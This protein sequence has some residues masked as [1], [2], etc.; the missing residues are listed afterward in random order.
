M[1]ASPRRSTRAA[2]PKKARTEEEK[3]AVV[4]EKAVAAVEAA[5]AVA[6]SSPAGKKKGAKKAAATEEKPAAVEVAAPVAEAAD[7][8][9]EQTP[10]VSAAVAADVPEDLLVIS[11]AEEEDDI[12]VDDEDKTF[13]FPGAEA[14]M[15]EMEKEAEIT[16]SI[17]QLGTMQHIASDDESDSSDDE[18]TL[19]RVGDIP[20]EWYKD[21]GHVGY[22]VEGRKLMKKERSAL[23]QLLD[24]TDDPN[25][26]RTIYDAL[27]DE[28]KVLSNAEL[29][30]IFNLQRN[31]TPNSAYDM[32]AD[33]PEGMVKFD[34]LN[35]PLARP[36]G[37][38]KKKFVPALHDM[39]VVAKMVK[40]LM[41]GKTISDPEKENPEDKPEH[42]YLL[43]DDA[44]HVQMDNKTKFKY[45]NR[46]EKPSAAPPGTYESYRPPAE[47]LPSEK[48]IAKFK[49]LRNIDKKE[50]FLPE[51][52]DSLRHVPFYKRTI[53][54]R[55][56]RCLDLSLYPRRQRTRLIVDPS[57]LLPELP[58]PKDLRPFPERLS[59]LYK[60]HTACVRSI[61]VNPTGEYLA[62][63]CDD[64]LVRV[65][66]VLTGRLMKRY[67]LG[68]PVQ[69]V[70]FSPS[71]SHN[72]LAAAVEYN[73]VLIVPTFAAHEAINEHSI[74]FLRASVVNAENVAA[75][76]KTAAGLGSAKAGGIT[77]TAID[78]D[79]TAYQ[80]AGDLHDTEEKE[81]RAD[82]VDGNPAERQAG[83]MV[84]IK[85]HAK[86]KKITFHA[87]GDYMCALCPKD[88]VKY[89]QTVMLQ[90][91]KRTV[92]CPF[93]KFAEVVTDCKFHPR[94]PLFFLTTT[95]SV[96]CYNLMQHKLQ[97]K[98]KAHGGLT[99]CL[100][101]HP[102]GD[103]FLVG[104]TTHHTAW[105][106]CDFSDKPYKRMKSH[107]GVVNSVEYHKNT[108][109]YPLFASGAS[110]GQ[111]HVFHGMVYDDYNQ[112]ALIVP[113]KILRHTRPVYCVTWHPTLPWVFTSTED[114]TVTCWTE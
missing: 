70:E 15:R 22:D 81:K 12:E 61:S 34:P 55:Y 10:A 2:T 48:A 72:I 97:K 103:N 110:D 31:R 54:D 20:L 60:G 42:M 53:Q 7:A 62:T 46:I 100:S 50:H 101:L 83:I 1:S 33:Y 8:D 14:L 74:R 5:A 4:E 44:G 27:H 91:S 92:F 114:G 40:R 95:N 18:G 113:V 96:R 104:D 109:A 85:M 94:E 68:G 35:H 66:E 47:Y 78:T 25:A 24:A 38:S 75:D 19:N 36:H 89:R 108:D 56:Q 29:E 26:Y 80:P 13:L 41:Q 23:Q 77:Q 105:F 3:P 93:R 106:D 84:K 21:E 98:Y 112:N 52:F 30:M 73:I 65:Y 49:R 88:H 59:F 37:P 90:L 102:D 39:K 63:A 43:W 79:E 64:H 107:K 32:Y 9:D 71:A 58:D 99:T 17:I 45:Y 6:A 16:G 111:V 28:K 69:Q 76:G 57:K 82:F 51:Q 87:K 67:D 86:V 11:D